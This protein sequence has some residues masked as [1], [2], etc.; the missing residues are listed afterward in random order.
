MTVG[1]LTAGDSYRDGDQGSLRVIGTGLCRGAA[2]T[3]GR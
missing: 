2:V 3:A 1:G